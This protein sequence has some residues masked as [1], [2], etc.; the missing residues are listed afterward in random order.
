M[1]CNNQYTVYCRG[2]T[3]LTSV[4]YI[5]TCIST[6]Y[7]RYYTIYLEDTAAASGGDEYVAAAVLMAPIHCCMSVTS[8]W[9]NNRVV[10]GSLRLA[11]IYHIAGTGAFIRET[12]IFHFHWFIFG[13]WVVKH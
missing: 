8:L 3:T 7:T 2:Y 1:V 6:Q 9:N 12:E 5:C 10:I 11:T 4:V 13:A